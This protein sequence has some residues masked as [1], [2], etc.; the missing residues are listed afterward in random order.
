MCCLIEPPVLS[1][2]LVKNTI[3]YTY[4]S[5]LDRFSGRIVPCRLIP[6]AWTACAASPKLGQTTNLYGWSQNM[7]AYRWMVKCW[8]VLLVNL[9]P[10]NASN[11]TVCL[12]NSRILYWR[13]LHLRGHLAPEIFYPCIMSCLWVPY[14]CS[15]ATS[16]ASHITM[17][18]Y[19]AVFRTL[20]CSSSYPSSELSGG[21]FLERCVET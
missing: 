17:V 16:P 14:L 19:L 6:E 10:H 13:H 12:E 11:A 3:A 9:N 15:N 4:I 2:F 1:Q 21:G 5:F 8:K 7:V 20:L 18:I